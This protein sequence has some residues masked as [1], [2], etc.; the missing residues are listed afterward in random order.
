MRTRVLRGGSWNNNRNN[1][2]CAVR[3]RNNPDNFNNNLFSIVPVVA[4]RRHILMGAALS[5]TMIH[6]Q[7][8][9]KAIMP[10]TSAMDR[11]RE[12]TPAQRQW[13]IMTPI[14]GSSQDPIM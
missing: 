5:G 4:P 2:R 1:V 6:H 8:P 10:Q 7:S 12:P 13:P 11:G 14:I 3:N 9:A